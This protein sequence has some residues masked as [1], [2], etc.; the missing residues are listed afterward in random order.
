MKKKF[1][2]A[3]CLVILCLVVTG[4]R[5]GKNAVITCVSDSTGSNPKSVYY[6]IYKVE[7]N[8]VVEHTSYSIK[9]FKE[10]EKVKI[11]D[12]I[13]TY[14]KDK[15]YKVKKLSKDSVKL[16]DTNPANIFKNTVSDD[17]PQTIVDTFEDNSLMLYKYTCDVK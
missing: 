16:T 14:K 4:C 11:D 17:L 10:D 1:F 6:E 9:T 13:E 8:K 3:I 2:G 7:D 12:Y 15:D 5:K